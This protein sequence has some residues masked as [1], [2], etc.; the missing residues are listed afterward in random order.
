MTIDKNEL[1]SGLMD[2]FWADEKARDNDLDA[3][4]SDAESKAKWARYHL[5]RDALQDDIQSPLDAGFASRVSAAIEGEPAIVAFPAQKSSRYS[6][7]DI[8]PDIDSSAVQGQVQD[9][10][11]TGATD[12]SGNSMVGGKFNRNLIGFSVAASVAVVS[13]VGLNVFQS[14]RDADIVNRPVEIA[15]APVN[16]V[17]N[18][19]VVDRSLVDGSLVNGQLELVSNRVGSYWVDRRQEAVSPEFASRLNMYLSEH[20]ESS[21]TADVKGMLPYSRL[22]GYDTRRPRAESQ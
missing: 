22:A 11:N 19:Q 1:M 4:L 6:V 7:Q 21:S 13:L 16:A 10:S 3:L 2:D 20:I 18:G 15:Q 12:S 5:I 9:D 8:D 14:S 17:G